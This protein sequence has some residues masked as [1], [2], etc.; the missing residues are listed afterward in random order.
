MYFRSEHNLRVKVDSLE[1]DLISMKQELSTVKS[2]VEAKSLEVANLKEK[3]KF[4]FYFF[5]I[6]K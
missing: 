2:K 6:N 1:I 5:C 3:S 4:Y